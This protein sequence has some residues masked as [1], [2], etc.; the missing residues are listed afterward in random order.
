MSQSATPVDP[1]LPRN[2][3]RPVLCQP[4]ACITIAGS[5]PL[6]SRR[7]FE[8]ALDLNSTAVQLTGPAAAR[9]AAHW[10]MQPAE[11]LEIM[12]FSR[13]EIAAASLLRVVTVPA[14][15]PASRPVLDCRYDGALG[16]GF[17]VR[18]LQRRHAIVE[19]YGFAATAGVTKM[20]FPRADGSTYEIGETHWVAPDEVMVLGVDRAH[21]QPVGPIDPALDIGGP[22]YSS[23]LVSDAG[24]AAAFLDGVL[25]LELR[26]EFTFESEGPRSGM[27]LP[28]G[29]RVRF[30]QWFAP[31]ACT[32]Y[33]VIMQL[34]QNG[35]RAPQSLGLQSRGIGLWSFPTARFDEVHARALTRGVRLLRAPAEIE[36]PGFGRVR[37]MVLATPDDFPVEVF[38]C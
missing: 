3:G 25:G 11:S 35:R 14:S 26:R 28:A 10:G 34:E 16:V 9:L 17:P 29:T 7:F 19:A 27:R 21:L 30:Q 36:S 4:L 38:Q 8:G 12:L 20:P 18:D 5:D 33:L 24:A 22:S 1:M 32:G 13:P 23:A 6:A 37:S 15:L 31:G 2:D